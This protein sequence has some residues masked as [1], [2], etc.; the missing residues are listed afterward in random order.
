MKREDLLVPLTLGMLVGAAKADAGGHADSAAVHLLIA[1][2]FFAAS[3]IC[4]AI[5]RI[6]PKGPAA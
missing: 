5:S 2:I 1:A 3:C 6:Q 4:A